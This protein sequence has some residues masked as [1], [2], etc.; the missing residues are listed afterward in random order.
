MNNRNLIAVFFGLACLALLVGIVTTS[1]PLSDNNGR[2]NALNP[3]QINQTLP[4]NTYQPP[5]SNILP[6]NVNQAPQDN[7][8]PTEID[9]NKIT[10]DGTNAQNPQDKVSPEMPITMPNQ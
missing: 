1:N 8:L 9:A 5:A 3:Q 10:N 2:S 4:N 6:N 7:T